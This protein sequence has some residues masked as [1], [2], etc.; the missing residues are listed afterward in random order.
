MSGSTVG[1]MAAMK[2]AA[3][4]APITITS[5]AADTSGDD[6]T[7]LGMSSHTL[8]ANR[9]CIAFV[10]N[11]SA[12]PPNAPTLSGWTQHTTYVESDVRRVTMLTRVVGSDTTESPTITFSGQT[13]A[14][15]TYSVQHCDANAVITGTAGADGIVQAL[16]SGLI[17]APA[18]DAAPALDALAAF[19]NVN[20]A[21]L[22]CIT[23]G[24]QSDVG[25]AGSG[26]TELSAVGFAAFSPMATITEYK[27]TN[28]T[29]AELTGCNNNADMWHGMAV[30][31]RHI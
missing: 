6:V 12:T 7:S 3:G 5:L 21:T 14:R 23:I 11:A 16:G 31:I 22:A 2:I 17:H 20:N 9:L 27:S 19:G 24:Y 26:W 30:E 1:V 4:G 28:D 15:V 18:V 10:T 25:D 8:P 29:T 13:Q